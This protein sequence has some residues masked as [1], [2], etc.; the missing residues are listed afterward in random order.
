[1]TE[2]LLT[3]AGIQEQFDMLMSVEQVPVRHS[4]RCATS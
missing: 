4:S 1:M 3:D 2:R